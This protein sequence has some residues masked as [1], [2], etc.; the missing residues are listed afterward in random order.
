MGEHDS[1]PFD[2]LQKITF[3]FITGSIESLQRST[4]GLPSF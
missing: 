4:S 3:R 1:V 2:T